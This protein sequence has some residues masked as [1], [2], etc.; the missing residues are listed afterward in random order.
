MSDVLAISMLVSSIVFALA[1]TV[2]VRESRR[3]RKE[4]K[5]HRQYIERLREMSRS[6]PMVTR[7]EL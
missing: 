3:M 6:M 7:L 1:V 4:L 2:E 5:A